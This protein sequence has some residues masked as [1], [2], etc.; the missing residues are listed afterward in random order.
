MP[1]SATPD[2]EREPQEENPKTV[3]EV[4]AE[5][6]RFERGSGIGSW[7]NKIT[8]REFELDDLL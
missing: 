4:D 2:S 6:L 5:I 7:G 8:Y 1:Y 3:D